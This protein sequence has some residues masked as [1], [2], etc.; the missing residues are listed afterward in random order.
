MGYRKPKDETLYYCAYCGN[1]GQE[2]T[3]CKTC[4]ANI[5]VTIPLVKLK[6]RNWADAIYLLQQL[7]AGRKPSKVMVERVLRDAAVLSAKHHRRL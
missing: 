6:L 3:K 4:G 2:S 1:P 7:A 5:N